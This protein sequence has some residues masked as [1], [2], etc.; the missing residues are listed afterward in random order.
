MA[1]T[2][3]KAVAGVYESIQDSVIA[4]DTDLHVRR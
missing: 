2:N 4:R 3:P 1:F